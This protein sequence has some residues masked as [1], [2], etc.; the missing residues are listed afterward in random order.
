[1]RSFIFRLKIMWFV[2]TRQSFILLHGDGNDLDIAA[3]VGNQ[4]F[5][6]LYQRLIKFIPNW[7]A[8]TFGKELKKGKEIQ[9]ET[10]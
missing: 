5:K 10:D 7:F 4:V 2:L 3:L 8:Q 1:M 6:S 9:D